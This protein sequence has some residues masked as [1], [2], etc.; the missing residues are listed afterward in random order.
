MSKVYQYDVM[1]I[2]GFGHVGL[3]LGIMLADIGLKVGLYDIDKSKRS[4]IES[5]KM[6]FIEHGAES[7]LR[8]VIGK[9]LHIVDEL[10]EVS[11]SEAIIISIGTPVDEY[12]NPKVRPML[13]LAEQFSN[14][15]H[16]GQ[17]VILRST[18]YPGTTKRLAEFFK[19]RGL[20]IHLGYC[21]ERVAQGFAI[22]ELRELPQIISGFNDDTNRYAEKLF[23]RLGMRIIEVTV[24][25][26]ELIKLFTNA[27]RYIQFAIANQFYMIAT[28]YGANYSRIYRAITDNYERA[29]DFPRSGFTAGPCLLKDTL[30]LA[31]FYDNQFQL[32]HAAMMVNEGL[33]NFIVKHLTQ[34]IKIDFNNSRVGILG[35][36]FKADIDD[37]RDSLSYKLAKI[38]KF[39][40]AVVVRSDEYVKDPNFVSKEELVT[41]CSVVIIAV[42]HSAYRRLVVPKGVYLVDLWDIIELPAVLDKVASNS[43]D[44][45]LNDLVK[46]SS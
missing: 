6:P 16:S 4:L 27:W 33:P 20:D 14:Y 32:G 36:A 2:G 21:P 29:K 7:I 8:R 25:E 12:L 10:R 13:E 41:T 17:Y 15:L 19:F 34:N 9:T 35:M 28:D 40:G 11:S 24:Q 5:G 44:A 31:A 46:E 26:A 23:K 43:V 18:V 22:Q 37:I 38:L 30:Q 42:P 39:H 1:V 45:G 3:P